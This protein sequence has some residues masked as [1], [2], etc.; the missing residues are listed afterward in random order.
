MADD[1]VNKANILRVLVEA[2]GSD[3]RNLTDLERGIVRGMGLYAN[4]RTGQNMKHESLS[5][6]QFMG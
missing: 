4:Y 3:Y 6:H 2:F 1:D 5:F